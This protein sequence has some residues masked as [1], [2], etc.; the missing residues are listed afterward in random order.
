MS[1]FETYSLSGNTQSELI[2]HML[3][4]LL[5]LAGDIYGDDGEL[6]EPIKTWLEAYDHDSGKATPELRAMLSKELDDV[7]TVK[8]DHI[9]TAICHYLEHY[10]IGQLAMDIM[11]T[12]QELAFGF[13]DQRN[14]VPAKYRKTLND[15]A[16][17]LRPL[18]VFHGDSAVEEYREQWS[19]MFH[20][21]KG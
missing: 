20:A 3:A 4:D 10:T 19:G 1:D 5:D 11:L 16:G 17:S 21:E 2:D 14:D 9:L 7:H 13:D 6:V 8:N 12:R 18:H 15:W